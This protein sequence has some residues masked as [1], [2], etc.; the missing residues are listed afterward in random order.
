MVRVVKESTDFTFGMGASRRLARFEDLVS[1]LA[2]NMAHSSD[3]PEFGEQFA[4]SYL[5][6]LMPEVP[7]HDELHGAWMQQLEASSA[8]ILQELRQRVMK[9]DDLWI[10]P[11]EAAGDEGYGPD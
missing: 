5:T 1:G 10:C 9:K 11:T 6:G 2:S 7:F 3:D 4:V 8:A